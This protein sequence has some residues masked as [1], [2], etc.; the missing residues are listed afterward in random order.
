MINS[1]KV[2]EF[3]R[4][5]GFDVCGI[6]T[7]ETKEN[8]EARFD[9]WIESGKHGEM[10]YLEN[11]KSR[12]ADFWNKFPDARSVIVL[13]V[14]YFS[15][16]GKGEACLALTSGK[17]ARYAWGKDY[18]RMILEKLKILESKIKTL[19]PSP[20]PSPTGRG[21]SL[22]GVKIRCLNETLSCLRCSETLGR[23]RYGTILTLTPMGDSLPPRT[24]RKQ[25]TPGS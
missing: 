24:R 16:S 20:Q 1:L 15:K 22:I 19:K 14:N 4:E 23:A 17:I 10:K 6:A 8:A 12:A 18:H 5:A 25:D 2:K 9:R 13:G 7:P 3:A 11:F 21:V